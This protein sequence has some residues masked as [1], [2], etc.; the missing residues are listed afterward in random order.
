MTKDE[1]D[2]ALAVV[3]LVVLLLLFS[4][5]VPAHY[6]TVKDGPDTP[7]WDRRYYPAE[8]WLASF[9]YALTGRTP[10]STGA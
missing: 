6:A 8:T 2:F 9:Y 1:K 7:A 4:V 10:P 3:C 5:R